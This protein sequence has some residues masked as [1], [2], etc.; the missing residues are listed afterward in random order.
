MEKPMNVD[1]FINESRRRRNCQ[2]NVHQQLQDVD[3]GVWLSD[4]ENLARLQDCIRREA[5]NTARSR[6]LLPKS[7][8]KIIKTLRM[9]YGQ[10]ERHA[11]MD[12]LQRSATKSISTSKFYQL[13]GISLAAYKSP[14]SY[15][16]DYTFGEPDA[17]LGVDREAARW[18]TACL[19]AVQEEK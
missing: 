14:R 9:L 1:V 16:A 10:P 6:L 3:E 13:Q 4:V 5:L 12:N 18:N 8:P 19:G 15:R 2:P 7:V 17:N 11:A